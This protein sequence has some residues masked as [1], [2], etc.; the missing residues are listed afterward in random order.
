M[1]GK[2][3]EARQALWAYR[4]ALPWLGATCLVENEA[5]KNYRKRPLSTALTRKSR[6]NMW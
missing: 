1:E 2:E 3:T 5:I 4:S 6:W